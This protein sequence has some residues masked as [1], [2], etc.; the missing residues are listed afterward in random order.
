M[1][2][3]EKFEQAAQ[4]LLNKLKQNPDFDLMQEYGRMLMRPIDSF[5][6]KEKQ[7]YDELTR[8]LTKQKA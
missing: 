1:T 7:R 4:K 3:Q 5:T 6:P 2:E 8:I